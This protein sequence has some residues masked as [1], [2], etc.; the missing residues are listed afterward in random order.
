MAVSA[1]TAGL[2]LSLGPVLYYWGRERLLDFYEGIAGTP[3]DVVYLGEVVCSKRRALR[4]EEWLELGERLAA[5]GKQ[6]VLSTLTLIEAESELATLRRLCDNGRFLVEANDMAAVRLLS[7][8]GGFVAGP[9]INAYNER[10]LTL[11]AGLGMRRWVLPVELSARTLA[12]LRARGPEGVEC[13][14][15]AFGRLPLAHSARCFTARAHGLPKDD[16]QYRCL[17]YPD[18]MTLATQEGQ[19]FLALNGI[20]TQS[21]QTLS[22]IAEL[23]EMTR[24]GVDVVRISPQSRG[25]E[26]VIDAFHR[27]RTGAIEPAVAAESLRRLMPVGP[28]DGYWHG[29]AG[30]RLHAL[31]G[32]G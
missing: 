32:G 14:V 24:L 6:V 2:K 21:A 20:Q 8:R 3:V 28:C 7:G 22:L 27:V 11:L 12:D 19:A 1:Q 5:G 13:E 26:E 29:E 17:D 31:A 4:T 30:I 10:T 9:G 25:T 15:F 18:G 16:C 23:P